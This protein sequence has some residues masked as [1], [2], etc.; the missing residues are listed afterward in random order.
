MKVE[1]LKEY[2]LNGLVEFILNVDLIEL[3]DLE[4]FDLEKLVKLI[5]LIDLEGFNFGI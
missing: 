3:V 2:C 1:E 4:N 5:D